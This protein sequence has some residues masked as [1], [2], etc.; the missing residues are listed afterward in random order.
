[1]EKSIKEQEDQ[2]FAEWRAKRPGFVADGVM[3]EEKFRGSHLRTVFLLKEPNDYP[4]SDLR[5]FLRAGACGTLWNTIAGW[6][7]AIMR[8]S[9][10]LNWSLDSGRLGTPAFRSMLLDYVAVVNL[11]KTSGL[12]TADELNLRSE[13]LED[14][15]LLRRQL[16]IYDPNLIISCGP[17]TS[18]IISEILGIDTTR[19][20]PTRRGVYFDVVNSDLRIVHFYHPVAHFPAN[21]MH[22][23]LTDAIREIYGVDLS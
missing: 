21:M 5:T 1:M 17:S 3:N 7:D 10:D 4:D 9:I 6:T 14:G 2:L 11:K 16:T 23:F 20:V 22:Y 13:A 15:D 8:L 12:G 19:R 18:Q